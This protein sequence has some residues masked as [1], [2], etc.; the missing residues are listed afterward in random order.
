[1]PHTMQCLP[2]CGLNTCALYAVHVANRSVPRQAVRARHAET[3][4]EY[5]YLGT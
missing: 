2:R 1:M 4:R 5:S 3:L